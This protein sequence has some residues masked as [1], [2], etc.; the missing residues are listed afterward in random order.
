MTHPKHTGLANRPQTALT[1]VRFGA[2][3]ISRFRVMPALTQGSPLRRFL[4]WCGVDRPAQSR[5]CSYWASVIE[6][7]ILTECRGR[8]PCS[9]SLSAPS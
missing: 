1:D 9:Q 8:L 2:R 5:S 4:G 3:S 7:S 6:F